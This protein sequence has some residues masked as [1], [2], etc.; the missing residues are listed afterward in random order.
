MTLAYY[1]YKAISNG[2]I[3]Y[4][5]CSAPGGFIGFTDRLHAKTNPRFI[6]CKISEYLKDLKV[7]AERCSDEE[8]D[9]IDHKL[10]ISL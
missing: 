7:V 6:H 8:W 10:V 9:T 5:H 1:R 4:F 2:Q 3:Y